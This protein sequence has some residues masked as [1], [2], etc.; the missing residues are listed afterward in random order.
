M[1]PAAY[2]F[3]TQSGNNYEF[4]RPW[5]SFWRQFIAFKAQADMMQDLNDVTPE[6][7]DS[8]VDFIYTW[9]NPPALVA[10]RGEIAKEQI[11]NDFDVS[12]MPEL[13]MLITSIYN[14]VQASIP[15]VGS[16]KARP[17]QTGAK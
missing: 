4:T 3:T 15:P 10:R 5:L 9:L 17:K 14:G 6:F 16:G 13:M 7:I 1:T 2:P 11:E 12:D 8:F